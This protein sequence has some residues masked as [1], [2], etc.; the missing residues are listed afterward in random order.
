MATNGNPTAGWSARDEQ[1][2]LLLASGNTVAHAAHTLGMGERTAY[3]KSIRPEFRRR[4]LQFRA[5]IVSEAVGRLSSH[6]ARAADRLAELMESSNENVAV[7][8]TKGMLQMG[9]IANE[10]DTLAERFSAIEAALLDRKRDEK[11][12][13]Y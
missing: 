13:Q 4:L 5:Q 12:R 11:A 2:C 3:R 9:F 10:Q 1:L 6:M 8:A 7:S